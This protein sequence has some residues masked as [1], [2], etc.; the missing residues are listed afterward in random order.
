MKKHLNIIVTSIMLLVVAFGC[1]PAQQP[2]AASA[3]SV[4]VPVLAYYY[5]WFDPSSWNRAKIDYPL[6]GRYSSDDPNVMRQH[7]LWAK[8]A[9]IQGFIVSWK[10][11]EVLSRRLAQLVQIAAQ[12]NFK[13]SI[14][15]EGLDFNRNPLPVGQV[16]SDLDY[17]ISKYAGNPVFDQFGKPL[18]IW[19][20]TWKFSHDQ[21][22][23]VTQS[24]R[25]RIQILASEKNVD[26]YRA[27]AD[28][29]DGDAYYWSSVNPDTYP[30]YDAK[31]AGLGDSVHAHQGLWIAPAAVGFDA[32]QIGGTTVV[33][34]KDGATLRTELNAAYLSSPNAIGII[35]WNE[36]SENSYIEPSQKYGKQYLDVL[37]QYFKAP[38]PKVAEIDSS[39]PAQVYSGIMNGS[40]AIA[41]G[42]LAFIILSSLA[43]IVWRQ[44]ASRRSLNHPGT[45]DAGK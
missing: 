16:A 22:A 31:L 12:E 13:L 25:D 1:V 39:D 30:N 33:D 10:N 43:V 19:S 38:S 32:R 26:G 28:L 11:T 18:V 3:V 37:T 21:I 36:F 44:V 27:I 14:I 6:L 2:P 41:L 42:V 4:P 23:G 7:I 34:R 24:R 8:S 40:Q 29:V 45:K 5:I 15:Y 20:G 35:S 17:F 9:G